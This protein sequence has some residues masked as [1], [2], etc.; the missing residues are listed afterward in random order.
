MKR[1]KKREAEGEKGVSDDTVEESEED[2]ASDNGPEE[3]VDASDVLKKKIL[4]PKQK[5]ELK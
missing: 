5:E 4:T 1:I 2:G 3:G